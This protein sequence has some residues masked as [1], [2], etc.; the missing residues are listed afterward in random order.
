[1]ITDPIP[2]G[3]KKVEVATTAGNFTILLY[4]D[5][6][7]H[8]DNF[9]KNVADSVYDGVLFHRVIKDF[10]VQAGDPESKN[11]PADKRLGSGQVGQPI[12][13]EIVFPKHFHKRGAL[14][15]ARTGD[16]VNPERK[17]SSSQFYIVTGQTYS[18]A[19]LDQMDQRL[20]YSLGQ[21]HFN[22]LARAH[23]AE[24]RKMQAERDT[25]GLRAL[26]A[27]LGEQTDTW[28][29][30]QNVGMTPEMREAYKKIGGTP[31]LDNEYTV[32]GEVISGMDVIDRI[33]KSPTGA[34]D[35]P[36]EDIKIISMKVLDD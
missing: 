14:A 7:G 27:Q 31:H 11:A 33:Q 5:T 21:Q 19:Q 20:K 1:M 36:V 26:Q 25:A 15:A 32:Y 13:A 17:S 30:T 28:L 35:R 34:A 29:S 22:E 24:I 2:A 10:M 23:E 8:R 4:G 6:P 18:D 12:P 9:L 16:Q 3:S